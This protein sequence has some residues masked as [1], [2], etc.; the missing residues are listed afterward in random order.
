MTD[1]GRAAAAAGVAGV[2]I[3]SL[4]VGH[5]NRPRPDELERY[6]TDVLEALELPAVLSTHFTA[7]YFVPLDLVDRLL[8]RFDHLVGVNCTNA[9]VT[10]L[11]AMIDAVGGPADVHVGGPMQ[12]L[13]N[14]A[15]GGQGYLSSEG[16]LAPALCRSATDRFH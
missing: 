8:A 2:Q 12:A 9:D 10:Y 4:D 3:Y 7:G 16:N 5:G 1:L 6:F 11:V 14:L 15:L 13:T